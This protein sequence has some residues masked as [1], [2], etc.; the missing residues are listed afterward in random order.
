MTDRQVLVDQL[1][2]DVGSKKNESI[3]QKKYLDDEFNKNKTRRIEALNRRI[4]S[5]ES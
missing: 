3:T 4:F 2:L 5:A 1:N